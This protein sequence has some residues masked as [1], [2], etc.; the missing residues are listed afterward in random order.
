MP[1]MVLCSAVVQGHGQLFPALPGLG[2]DFTFMA[3]HVSLSLVEPA[4]VS[5]LKLQFSVCVVQRKAKLLSWCCFESSFAI[6][7]CF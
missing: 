2:F 1:L 3:A 6:S 4:V 7:V 5:G